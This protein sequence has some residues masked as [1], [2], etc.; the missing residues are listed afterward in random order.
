MKL[1]MGLL[2]RASITVTLIV[3]ILWQLGGVHKI[4]EVLAGAHPGYVFLTLIVITADRALM[5]YKWVWLMRAQES[6]LPLLKGM[7]I[8]CASQMWGLILPSTMGADAIRAF[9]STQAGLSGK[10]VIA[11]IVIERMIGFIAALLL[12]LI[13]L[14]ILGDY[15]MFDERLG[16]IWWGASGLLVVAIL[17]FG[18]S[19]SDTLYRAIYERLLGRYADGKWIG[20]IRRVHQEYRDFRAGKGKLAIFFFLTFIEQMFSMAV[21]WL[22]ARALHVEVGI[23]FMAGAIPLALLVSRLPLSIDGLGVFEAVF[24]FLLAIVDVPAAAAVAIA[25]GARVLQIVAWTPWW[26]AYM[27]ETKRFKVRLQESGT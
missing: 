2:W 11:S 26:L 14:W 17:V 18:I 22:V 27:V 12:G 23:L 19:L 9:L 7:R 13:A 1:S 10:R 8:Y 3:V 24:I 4:G 20:R 25:L 15:V 21:A 5:T 6:H 16:M